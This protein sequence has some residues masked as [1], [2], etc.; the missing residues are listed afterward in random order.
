MDEVIAHRR[1]LLQEV[2]LETEALRLKADTHSQS[3]ANAIKNSQ[4]KNAFQIKEGYVTG[5]LF[6]LIGTLVAVAILYYDEMCI[7]MLH[8]I[9][10]DTL[11]GGKFYLVDIFTILT[12]LMYLEKFLASIAHPFGIGSAFDFEQLAKE[13]EERIAQREKVCVF[14][15]FFFSVYQRG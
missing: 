7:I 3:A 2:S 14:F 13:K 11:H 9:P 1:R 10:G 5:I 15:S 12:C 8:L 4:I 6:L